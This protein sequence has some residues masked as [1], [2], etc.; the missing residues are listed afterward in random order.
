MKKLTASF[1]IGT[2]G[3]PL[4]LAQAHETRQRLT[5]ALRLDEQA[6]DMLFPLN[7]ITTTG[8]AITDR[9]LS[10]S[11]GKGLFTKEIDATQLEGKIAIA[12]HSA[13]DLPT[14]LPEGLLIAG[15]LPREDPRDALISH[16]NIPFLQL[17]HGAVIGTASLRR[18]AMLLHARPDLKVELLRG[19]VGTRLKK[20]Q[21]GEVS[22]TLLA[23]AGL[24]RLHLTHHISEALEIDPFLPAV[25]Q[26][27][28]ALVSRKNDDATA[29][30]LHQIMCQKTG[31]ALAAERAFLTVLDGSCRTP[32]AAYAYHDNN[33][34]IFNG[35][36]LS[37][38]GQHVFSVSRHGAPHD[39]VQMGR[40][41]GE[42]I[43]HRASPFIDW[44]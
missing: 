19:N 36:V 7:V 28:I 8:D 23:M 43:K 27:A 4:A 25:G 12:V 13:K 2:R 41:A 35:M 37:P 31:E 34:L 10:E 17:P 38:D 5:S 11:G 14:H 18:Q 16:N 42:E 15:Y 32:L 26:G 29:Q 40:D 1:P 21:S 9:A 20:V 6:V 30:Y 39:G 22:A 44:L 3:S 33:A 24:N